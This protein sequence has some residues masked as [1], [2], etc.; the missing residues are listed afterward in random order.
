MIKWANDVFVN[1]KKICGILIENT[2][3]GANVGSS[4][5]G[6]GL[7]VCNSLPQELKEIATSMERETGKTFCVE[8]V[9]NRLISELEKPRKM[10]EYLTYIGYMGQEA[11]LIVGE[12]RVKVTLVSVDDEGGLVVEIDGERKR[13]LSAE[14]SLRI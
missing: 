7:N 11:T 13:F 1:G 6:I 9:A 3:S 4:V 5:V 8:E 14:V 2:F 10:Q 12:E